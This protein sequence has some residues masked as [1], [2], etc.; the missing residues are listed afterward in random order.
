LVLLAPKSRVAWRAGVGIVALIVV[1]GGLWLA[2]DTAFV[3]SIEPLAR[4]TSITYSE[5]TIMS[6]FMNIS[7]AWEGFK[8]RP[9]LGWGQENYAAV[10]DKNYNPAMYAQEP[11]FD[12]THNV[13]LD[14][15]IAGGILGLLAY[16]SLYL[17]VSPATSFICS[18]RSTTSRVISYSCRSLPIS[19]RAHTE[20]RALCLKRAPHRVRFCRPLR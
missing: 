4:L 18:L 7:M 2:R 20:T 17:F 13:I 9:I 8:E 5:G 1:A 12:R 3:R 10:F 11:W 15:L 19:R 14:W 16:L 6:R